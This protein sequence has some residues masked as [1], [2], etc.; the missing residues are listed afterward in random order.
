M[1]LHTQHFTCLLWISG[2]LFSYLLLEASHAQSSEIL[3]ASYSLRCQEAWIR[4]L[5]K[6][7]TLQFQAEKTFHYDVCA[8]SKA[9]PGNLPISEKSQKGG[10]RVRTVEFIKG[11]PPLISLVI[12]VNTRNHTL[13]SDSLCQT[14]CHHLW[15]RQIQRSQLWEPSLEWFTCRRMYHHLKIAFTNLFLRLHFWLPWSN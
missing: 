10:N 6:R 1:C 3:W 7:P 13:K 9:D 2:H 4:L 5:G 8:M 14:E 11:I 15:W 12:W